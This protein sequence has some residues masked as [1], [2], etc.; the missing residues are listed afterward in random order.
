MASR[1]PVSVDPRTVSPL[2]CYPDDGIARFPKDTLHR[3]SITLDLLADLIGQHEGRSEAVFSGNQKFA[4]ALQ[5]TG[6]SDLTAAVADGLY[7][8]KETLNPDEIPV[9]LDREERDKLQKLA[10][11]FE[12]SVAAVAASFVRERLETA[13]FGGEL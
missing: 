8:A 13:R 5:L 1:T 7:S 6:L 2:L 12:T 11:R 9:K 3:I 4:L 10:A